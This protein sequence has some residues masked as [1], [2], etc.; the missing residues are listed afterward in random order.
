MSLRLKIHFPSDRTSFQ[1]VKFGLIVILVLLYTVQNNVGLADNGDWMRVA[2]WF[3][4][5]PVGFETNWP[6]FGT[7]EWNLRFYRYWLP[8]WN[9]DFPFKT[10]LFSSALLLWYPGVILN[11]FFFS[12]TILYLP[13][14]SLFPKALTI[15]FLWLVFAYVDRHSKVK[16]IPAIT[17]GGPLVL[18][19][20]CTDIVAYSNSFY[21]ETASLIFFLFT[22]LSIILIQEQP[23]AASYTLYFFSVLLLATAKTSNLYWPIIAFPFVISIKSIRLRPA[24]F[25]LLVFILAVLPS[26]ISWFFAGDDFQKK[27]N[28]FHSIFYGVMMFSEYPDRRLQEIGMDGAEPCIGQNA[29]TP[30][31]LECKK[32]YYDEISHLKTIQI[33]IR[34]PKALV[35]E[36]LFM[37]NRMQDIT[38]EYMGHYSRFDPIT[39]RPKKINAW[40]IIK[41]EFFPRG[42]SL[43]T[44]LVIFVIL[45]ISVAKNDP[46]LRS[47]AKAGMLT[48]VVCVVDILV[49]MF[50]DGLREP[51]KH[52]FLA[53]LAFDF[54]LIIAVTIFVMICKRW[55]EEYL[56]RYLRE[57]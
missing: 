16:T 14:V 40:P 27:N 35:K 50:G 4:S 51:D 1:F 28:S 55:V 42:L 56:R 34:E 39:I 17:L 37:A 36:F 3:S 29:Y 26:M 6:Q 10:S 41:A 25:L 53:N 15:V 45:G 19:F 47:L 49:A 43:I 7:P 2:G 30:I 18:I 52:L 46:F 54:S 38:L 24:K 44:A 23:A 31:G 57:S 11:R 21:Q 48:S 13:L 32:R 9:L 8:Y 33:I 12:Y 5:G 20:S 22:I